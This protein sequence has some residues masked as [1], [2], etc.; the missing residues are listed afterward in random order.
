MQRLSLQKMRLL[1]ISLLLST[2]LLGCGGLEYSPNQVFDKN[3]NVDINAKNLEKL[4][5]GIGDDTVRFIVMGDPQRSHNEVNGFY[6]KVNSMQ[7]IDFVVVAGDISEFGILKEMDAIANSL[8]NLNMPY[9]AVVGNHDLTARGREVFLRMYGELNY[10][11]VY[12]GVKFICH[13][14]NSREYNF[15]GTAPDIAWLEKELMPESGVD[16]FV[17]I[18]HVPPNSLDFDDSLINEYA[19]VFRQATGFLGSFHGHNHAFEEFQL[20]DED[21]SYVVTSTIGKKEFLVVEIVNNKLS[22]DQ[23]YY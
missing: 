6:K 10:T 5:D 2:F 14:T 7:G 11:F 12:G 19:G 13:D 1:N 15:N 20:G 18:S 16:N 8:N 21:F 3:S 23:I 22:F 17:A 4:G 9:L